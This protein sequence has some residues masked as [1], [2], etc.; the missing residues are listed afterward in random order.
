MI[1]RRPCCNVSKMR[2]NL[3]SNTRM[4]LDLDRLLLRH[5]ASMRSRNQFAVEA[6]FAANFSYPMARTVRCMEIRR[7][8]VQ[9]ILKTFQLVI[10]IVRRIHVMAW[11]RM[12]AGGKHATATHSTM[13]K[14]IRFRATRSLYNTNRKLSRIRMTLKNQRDWR[15]SKFLRSPSLKTTAVTA[16]HYCLRMKIKVASYCQKWEINRNRALLG[17]VVRTDLKREWIRRRSNA[18]IRVLVAI[19]QTWQRT[20]V[21]ARGTRGLGKSQ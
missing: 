18:R 12:W 21:Q 2:S 16:H 6:I 15:G 13:T 7:W 17:R 19:K 10:I 5:W 11:R 20:M 14:M 8:R 4:N 9:R 3:P 1:I